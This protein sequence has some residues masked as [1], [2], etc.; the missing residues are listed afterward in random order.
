AARA[1]RRWRRHA[2]AP[3][4]S[5]TARPARR[6][7]RRGHPGQGG[8]WWTDSSSGACKSEQR[9]RTLPHAGAAGTWPPRCPAAAQKKAAGTGP[10]A[11]IT[12]TRLRSELVAEA[13]LHLPAGLE[14]GHEALAHLATVA[15]VDVL[16]GGIVDA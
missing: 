7:G 9:A 10:A 12:H 2:A 6:A 1:C 3:P 14:V 8:C 13:D 5:A 15:V 11:S 16:A 4:R